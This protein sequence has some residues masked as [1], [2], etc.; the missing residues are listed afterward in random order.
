MESGEVADERLSA[1]TEFN[2]T[3][4]AAKARL[5]NL[6][7]DGSIGA[8]VA[9]TDDLNQWLKVSLFRQINITGVMIQ[10]RPSADQWVTK[11]KV[12]TSLGNDIWT[13]VAGENGTEEVRRKM[14]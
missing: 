8:W 13:P 10:G 4:S 9:G 1:S 7:S 3:T 12:E 2:T 14:S 6:A 5:N 11:F